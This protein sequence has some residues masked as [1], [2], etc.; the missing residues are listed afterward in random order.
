[1]FKRLSEEIERLEYENGKDDNET[2]CNITDMLKDIGVGEGIIVREFKSLAIVL[3]KF[4]NDEYTILVFPARTKPNGDYMIIN[5]HIY[6]FKEKVS[7]TMIEGFKTISEMVSN[8]SNDSQVTIN[9]DN[10][11]VVI[12]IA[13]YDK[14][15]VYIVK[16]ILANGETTSKKYILTFDKV[17]P[18]LS[19]IDNEVITIFDGAPF[20]GI[21]NMINNY[22]LSQIRA[23][24]Q[25]IKINRNL[26]LCISYEP[27]F[28]A[29]K[30]Y[31]TLTFYP[32]YHSSDYNYELLK[33]EH[34]TLQNVRDI[35]DQ[36]EFKRK[37]KKRLYI[38]N[39]ISG[40]NYELGFKQYNDATFEYSVNEIGVIHADDEKQQYEIRDHILMTFE[41]YQDN[42]EKDERCSGYDKFIV[43]HTTDKILLP[44]SSCEQSFSKDDVLLRIRNVCLLV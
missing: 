23:M 1:M 42:Y 22:A 18:I 13:D 25:F 10:H 34:L 28:I 37:F 24:E 3:C 38:E 30:M 44:Q 9:S 11:S 17:Y 15:I 12:E 21:R 19:L 29:D 20:F 4:D 6:R 5:Q 32:R 33:L 31:Y 16:D 40:I 8:D 27:D 43:T 41:E 14:T 26:S 7:K 35:N 2:T 39:V 36:L